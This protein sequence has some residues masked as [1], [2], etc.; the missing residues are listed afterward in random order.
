LRPSQ[1]APT[2]SPVLQIPPRIWPAL[3]FPSTWPERWR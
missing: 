2:L 1:L 3:A